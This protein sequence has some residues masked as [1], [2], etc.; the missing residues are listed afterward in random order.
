MVTKR[1][2]SEYMKKFRD[3]KWETYSKCYE[4]ML[5][6]RLTRRLLEH[7]H[8]PWFWSGSDSDSDSGGR[9]PP[10]PSKNQVGSET[11]RDRTQA[12]LEQCEGARPDRQQQDQQTRTTGQVPRLPLQQQEQDLSGVHG[13]MRY[14]SHMTEQTVHHTGTYACYS[15][16]ITCGRSIWSSM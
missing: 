1:I 5:K 14:R 9:S 15:T 4:E 7:T 2:R 13:N 8:N 11:S 16:V 12:E 6:Y 3:P 10:P